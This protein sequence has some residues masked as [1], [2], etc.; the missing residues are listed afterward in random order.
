MGIRKNRIDT[1][2]FKSH[3]SR[4]ASTSAEIKPGV[5]LDSIYY[6]TAGWTETAETFT[7]LYNRSII[8]SN[9]CEFATKILAGSNDLII[10]IMIMSLIMNIFVELSC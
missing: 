10:I 4:Y 8:I 2:I 6:K 5:S 9:P 3:S 7:R 1:N